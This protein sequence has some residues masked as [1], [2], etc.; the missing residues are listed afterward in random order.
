[1]SKRSVI[2]DSNDTATNSSE[3]ELFIPSQEVSRLFV[4]SAFRLSTLALPQD[5]SLY[6]T[7]AQELLDIFTDMEE[8]SLPLVQKSQQTSETL[9]QL[10]TKIEAVHID[11][12]QQVQHS[13][14]K[15][16]QLELT[17]QDAL[18]RERSCRTVL[19]W[20][21]FRWDATDHIDR[22]REHRNE[23]NE[24]FIEQMVEAVGTL[25]QRHILSA[26]AGVSTS[27]MI[28]ALEN[29]MK[30]LLHALEQ[31]DSRRLAEAE[32]VWR[33]TESRGKIANRSNIS[34]TPY[35]RS[36][37]RAAREITTRKT[38]QSAETPKGLTSRYGT[39][40]CESLFQDKHTRDIYWHILWIFSWVEE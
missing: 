12:H 29:R 14:E 30:S 3:T 11:Q 21:A 2:L 20:D 37:C 4:K 34:V 10:Q 7:Q 40:L 38:K 25:Y 19:M 16:D 35:C 17:V 9:D 5:Y 8:K 6:F 28:E 22:F 27:H 13:Q 23:K 39:T 32:K 33:R 1:M 31:A 26:D 24:T 36:N 15:I 18:E